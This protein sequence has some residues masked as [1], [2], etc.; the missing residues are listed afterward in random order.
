MEEA[1]RRLEGREAR[2]RGHDVLWEDRSAGGVTHG[3]RAPR[4][5]RGAT[6]T[7]GR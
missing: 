6:E 4:D 3:S 2:S 1:E 7:L 5:T